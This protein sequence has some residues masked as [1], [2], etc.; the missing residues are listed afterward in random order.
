MLLNNTS[1]YNTE[2]VKFIIKH[3]AGQID[4]SDVAIN[5]KNSQYRFAG[6]AFN[7]I[8]HVSPWKKDRRA[9]FLIVNRV[10]GPS[11]FPYQTK[12]YR[13]RKIETGRWPTP[14]LAD[15]MECMVMLVAHELFHIVQY[16]TNSPRSEQETE[17]YG[18]RRLTLWREEVVA[19]GL[20]S[21]IPQ[22]KRTK[23]L[24]SA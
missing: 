6:R 15:W 8:P 13:G 1:I 11:L 21:N 16:R 23:R 2:L 10:G 4:I 19:K 3:A 18:M 22:F 17:A 24:T 7:G 12:G 20:V 14:L 5:I 9:R